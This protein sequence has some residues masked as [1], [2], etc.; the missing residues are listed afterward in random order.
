MTNSVANG[1]K[2]MRNNESA[3]RTQ[4]DESESQSDYEQ[5]IRRQDGAESSL[6]HRL[7]LFMAA[8]QKLIKPMND[9][10]NK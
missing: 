7:L 2:K 8:V 1:K 6:V 10:K 3:K 9:R 4:E 5:P